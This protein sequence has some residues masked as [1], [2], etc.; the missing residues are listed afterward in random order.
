MLSLALTLT[1][2]LAQ[3]CALAAALAPALQALHQEAYYARP[4]FHASVAWALLADAAPAAPA[5]PRALLDGLAAEFGDTVRRGVFD[6]AEVHVRIGRDV[7]AYALLGRGAQ[8][9]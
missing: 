6:V 8:G 1:L 4:R 3:F 5:L 2:A 9:V 7:S